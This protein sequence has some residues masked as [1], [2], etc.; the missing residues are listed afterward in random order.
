MT[1]PEG[2][3]AAV[4]ASRPAPDRTTLL[5]FGEGVEPA[6]RRA[7]DGLV[8]SRIAREGTALAFGTYDG[9]VVVLDARTLEVTATIQAYVE[10]TEVRSVAFAPGGDRIVCT[11]RTGGVAVCGVAGPSAVARIDRTAN[12]ARFSPDGLALAIA[13]AESEV[14]ILDARDLRTLRK[15]S[16]HESRVTAILF[17]PPGGIVTASTDGTARLWDAQGNEVARL[18]EPRGEPIHCAELSPDGARLLTGHQDGTVVLWD[19]RERRLL[20]TFWGHDG[21]VK[22]VS[23]EGDG[24]RALSAS[25]D[26]TIRR[27]DLLGKDPGRLGRF[28]RL[29][30][31]VE[32]SRDGR[33][34]ACAVADRTVRL[35]DLEADRAERI[36]RGHGGVAQAVAFGPTGDRLASV[37]TD[38]EIRIHEV[39]TG[40]LS[41][42]VAGGHR[43]NL[44]VSYSP[45]GSLLATGG[46]EGVRTWDAETL[47]RRLD[48]GTRNWIWTANFT[49]D[50]RSIVATGAGGWFH[51][52]DARTG[53]PVRELQATDGEIACAAFTADGRT[54]V[55]GGER[56][57]DVWD[58]GTWRVRAT[59]L[60]PTEY[61]Q[62]VAPSA[63]G[64]RIAVASWGS[65]RLIDLASGRTTIEMRDHRAI[66]WAVAFHPDGTQFASAAGG[67]E[68]QG[69]EV[70]L[71]GRL[72]GAPWP[73]VLR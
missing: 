58:V 1:L 45:D 49:P 68:G 35:F 17:D 37:S 61:I 69:C 5:V 67:Y 29:A 62:G 19:L 9:S 30:R 36:L 10:A 39:S 12:E 60:L 15:L 2:G 25:S 63:D 22:S 52:W 34:L 28:P 40:N 48:L 46:Q 24:R 26:G 7:V 38:G 16:G 53:A 65:V 31:D 42:S 6:E 70:R 73:P 44:A 54:L 41:C 50:G 11:G 64:T 18:I 27:W 72:P 56:R 13:T 21:W 33:W 23:F 14:E 71:W 32:Y 51:V 3:F 8:S 55:T 20:E 47:E 43:A 4:G 66:V 57:I 59:H